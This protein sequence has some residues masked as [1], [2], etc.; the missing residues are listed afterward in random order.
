MCLDHKK[1]LKKTRI[2]LYSTPA[3][4]VLLY[5]SET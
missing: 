4:A 3:L 1:N 2:K 5:D